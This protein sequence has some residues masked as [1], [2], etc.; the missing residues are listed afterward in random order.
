MAR[1]AGA[2]ALPLGPFQFPSLLLRLLDDTRF[3]DI[4]WGGPAPVETVAFPFLSGLRM[5][6]S[7]HS[8][9]DSRLHSLE[10]AAAAESPGKLKQ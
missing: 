5:T 4:I 3:L 9:G 7:Q 8:A 2:P 1:L 10:R 6:S